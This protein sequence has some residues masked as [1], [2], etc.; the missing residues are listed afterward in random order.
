MK[1]NAICQCN[2]S[3]DEYYRHEIEAAE[4][5]MPVGHK[6]ILSVGSD[7]RQFYAQ[8]KRKYLSQFLI[9]KY[10]LFHF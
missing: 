1:W 7:F 3:G 10:L 9:F 2:R 4:M 8:E 5:D 6:F